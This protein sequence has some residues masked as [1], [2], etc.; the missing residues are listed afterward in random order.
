MLRRVFTSTLSL[1]LLAGTACGTETSKPGATEKSE[2]ATPE[3]DEDPLDG[4]PTPGPWRAV[5]YLP[6]YRSLAPE[7]VNFDALTHLCIAFAN[8]TGEGSES[9]FEEAARDKI[10]PLVEAAHAANVMVLA[11]IAGGTA[12]SGELVAAQTEPSRVDAYVSGLVDLVERYELDGID[13]DIEGEAVNEDYEPF[14]KKLRAALPA[15]KLLT[16]AIAT[17]NG[18][19]VTDG[20]LETYDFVNIMAYDH[21]S[22][23]DEACD[24]AS[25]QG[26]LQDLD[27]WTKERG[28]PRAKA[29]VGVPF[30]GWCWGCAEKQSALTY[31]QILRQ[32]PEAKTQDWIEDGEKTISLNSAETISAKAELAREYGGIMIWELGQDASGEDSL[33][34]LLESAR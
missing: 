27:Y 15:D 16:A 31:A 5:G 23:T 21:C 18:P 14:V 20:A 1:S 26:V 33:L 24:Q 6:T 17:K 9:D 11:S 22:W 12:E 13:N 28:V 2:T 8:P 7:R 4:D 32:Y 19:P 3:T 29:V 25:L 10:A 30:Y 34:N